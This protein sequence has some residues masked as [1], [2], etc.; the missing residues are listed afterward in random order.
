MEIGD[1]V[2]LTDANKLGK[3]GF[4]KG[5]KGSCNALTTVDGKRYIH[6]QPEYSREVFVIDASRCVVDEEAKKNS[7][8]IEDK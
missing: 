2:I 4:R 1:P 7:V 5:L 3:Y 6:F 8:P